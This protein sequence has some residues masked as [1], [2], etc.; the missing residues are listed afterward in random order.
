MSYFGPRPAPL[1]VA[2][3]LLALG[4]LAAA[5]APASAQGFTCEASALAATLGPSPRTEP[6]TA[7]KTPPAQPA[8]K[9]AAAGGNA[10]ASPLPLTGSLLSATTD[11]QPPTGAPSAQT[12]SAAGGVGELRVAGLPIPLRRPDT[13]GLP[14]PQTIAGVTIDVRAAVEALVPETF[15]AELLH[16]RALRALVTGRCANGSPQLTGSSSV[17]GISVLGKELPTD[18]A[19]SQ[20]LTV[21]DSTSIDPSNL[22]PQQL[23]IPGVVIDGPIKQALDALPTVS[24]PATV[25]RVSATPGRKIEGGGKLIQ[26][27]LD[28]TVAVGG[29]TV[30]DLTVGEATV[31]AAQVVCGGVADLALQCTAR[32]IVLIDVVRSKGRV[33]LLG[34]ASRRFAGKRVKIRFLATG[35]VVARP[36]VRTSGLFSA[37]AKLPPAKLRATNRARYRAEISKQRSLRLKL[38]RRMLVSTTTVRDRRVTIAGR[39]VRPLGAPVRTVVVKRRLSCGRYRVIKRFTPP[40]SGRFRITVGGPGSEQAAVYRLQTRVRKFTSNPK[41]FPTFTLPRYVDLAQ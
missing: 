5:P 38:V 41:L 7:N 24:V 35:K 1:P 9:A 4:L 6:V 8:C 15:D 16:L 27:A 19:V 33:R 28:L 13:S 20:T 23:G 11:L 26:H 2:L 29:Q 31:G 36:V 30:A 22:T 3:C 18:R 34:A 32:G 25:A 37:T 12:A 17:L 21:S 39:V 10:P 40:A 14:G